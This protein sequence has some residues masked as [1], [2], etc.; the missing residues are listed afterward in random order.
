[1]TDTCTITAPAGSGSLNTT[2]GDWTPG[3]ATTLYS[4]P[5]RVRMPSVL[6]MD[7]LFGGGSRA[8]QRMTVIITYDAV[9]IPV[10]ARVVVT[11]STDLQLLDR[12]LAV[13]AVRSRSNLVD[14]RLGCEEIS[15]RRQPGSK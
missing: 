14:R 5:C 9:D 1:M 2:T 10:G 11:D 6:E 7:E 4:G 15:C 8:K 13:V 3:A 12:P